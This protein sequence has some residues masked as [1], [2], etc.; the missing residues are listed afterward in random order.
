[1]NIAWWH[2]LSVPT[3]VMINDIA[4]SRDVDEIVGTHKIS[5]NPASRRSSH[6]PASGAGPSSQWSAEHPARWHRFRPP[7][8]AVTGTGLCWREF[9]VSRSQAVRAQSA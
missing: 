7:Q 2:R 3:G 5:L 1:M 9:S 4:W 6:I 8:V